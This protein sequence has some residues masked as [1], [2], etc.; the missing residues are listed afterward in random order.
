MEVKQVYKF[1][2]GSSV[3]SV[4]EGLEYCREQMGICLSSLIPPL[5]I[6]KLTQIIE[7]KKFDSDITNYLTWRAEHTALLTLG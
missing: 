1:F 3:D 5:D 7:D 6:C 2:D 4:E